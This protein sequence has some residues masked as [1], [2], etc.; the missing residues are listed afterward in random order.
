MAALAAFE[1]ADLGRD[2]RAQDKVDIL[3][4]Y[5]TASLQARA[6]LML[7]SH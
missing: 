1:S 5:W 2:D 4:G 3:V 6:M 7:F